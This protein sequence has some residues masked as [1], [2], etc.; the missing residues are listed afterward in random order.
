MHG[1]G[2]YKNISASKTYIGNY[3]RGVKEGYGECTYENGNVYKG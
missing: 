2:I 1:F 3:N